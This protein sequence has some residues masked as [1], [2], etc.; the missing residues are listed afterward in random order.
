MKVMKFICMLL[1]LSILGVVAEAPKPATLPDGTKKV[2]LVLYDYLADR[3]HPRVETDGKLHPGL[4]ARYTKEL[5]Q[6]QTDRLLKAL[7]QNHEPTVK[8]W[9]DFAPH[10]GIVFYDADDR[11][12]GS[13]SICFYCKQLSS[14]TFPA[15]NEFHSYWDWSELKGIFKDAGF[16]ILASNE[17]YT[18]LR[19]RASQRV[20]AEGSPSAGGNG[21]EKKDE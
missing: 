2:S 4:I 16:P 6:P 21:R 19:I 17:A 15:Q 1:A 9:C 8:L 3:D 11:I 7:T 5:D 10:H 18:A 12:I 14:D 13:V 20:E